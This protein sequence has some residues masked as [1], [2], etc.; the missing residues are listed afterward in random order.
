MVKEFSV[1][2]GN[3]HAPIKSPQHKRV[4]FDVGGCAGDGSI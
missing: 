2:S 4:V 3:G 1:S